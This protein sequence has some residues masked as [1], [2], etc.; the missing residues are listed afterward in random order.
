MS[1]G[2]ILRRARAHLATLAVLLFSA[3]GDSA[4]ESGGADEAAELRAL[5][6]CA[7]FCAMGL[8]RSAG[9]EAERGGRVEA[10]ASR[11]SLAAILVVGVAIAARAGGD[12]HGLA[13]APHVLQPEEVTDDALDESSSAH[14]G[15]VGASESKSSESAG[16]V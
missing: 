9:A 13:G 6:Q 5:S 1:D 15:R 16:G 11:V 12:G 2:A 14:G 7:K 10:V 4:S 8:A 3:A